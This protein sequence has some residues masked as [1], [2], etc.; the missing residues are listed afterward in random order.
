MTA[1]PELEARF[2]RLG[3]VEEAIAM[4]H[5]DAA[6]MMPSGGATA[7]SEQL[8][9]LRLIAH[10]QL[11]APETGD[12][13]LAAD[14]E[15][16]ALGAWQE[17]NLREMR[18]RWRHAA[19]VPGDLVAALSRACSESETMWRAARPADD[20][21]AALPGMQ[22]VLELTR[23]VSAAKAQ[24]LG[25]SPYEAL[26]DQY[27]PGGSTAL[28]DR[29]FD[30]IVGFLPGLLDAV[31]SRQ[32]ARPPLTQPRGPFTIA[33]QR[34]VAM[35]LMARIGFDFDHGRIDESAHPF[36]GGTPDDIRLTTRYDTEDY[37]KALM[38]ALHETGHALYKRHLPAAWRRQ[39]VGAARGMAVH[40]SQ[41]LFLE[42]QICRSRAFAGFAAPIL[43][44]I[45]GG[46]PAAWTPDALHRRQIKVE[47]GLIRVDADEVTYPA[48]V[49]L[50][51][52]L[53][54]AMIA[55]DLVPRDLPGAWAEGM[56]NLLGVVPASDRDGCLQDIH[57]YDGAWGY[58]PTYTL[59]AL[60]AAQLFAAARDALPDLTGQVGRGEFAPLLHWLRI[61]IH[62]KGSLLST[63]ELV[64]EATGAPLGTAAFER[65]LRTRYLD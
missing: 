51:Y 59:G 17:A 62:K 64:R 10:E 8:A 52:R 3:T 34:R 12:L 47:R 22:R 2:R 20:F 54:R 16:P 1:Y 24:A 27:E 58:F 30:E 33:D 65:H 15:A 36:C 38:G 31:L 18:R 32:A 55:G 25:T 28:I 41:S 37:G 11:T 60:I 48:H 53:E 46:D 4:L 45:F 23:E 40:E 39:P 49:I 35:T 6:A 9:T 5:W 21:A 56:K 14:N 57:W 13:L 7:R 61:N 42:M 26:L 29:L 50:R 63:E 43:H 19:A 44:E